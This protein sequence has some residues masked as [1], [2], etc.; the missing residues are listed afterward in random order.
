MMGGRTNS[1]D[2]FDQTD[3]LMSYKEASLVETLKTKIKE[4]IRVL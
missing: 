2:E 4:I 3:Q 1:I